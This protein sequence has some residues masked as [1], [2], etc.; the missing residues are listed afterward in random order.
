MSMRTPKRPPKSVGVVCR[1][2]GCLL[3]PWVQRSQLCWCILL[4]VLLLSGGWWQE[5]GQAVWRAWQQYP[6]H[7]VALSSAGC[8]GRWLCWLCVHLPMTPFV[9]HQQNAP[10]RNAAQHSAQGLIVLFMQECREQITYLRCIQLLVPRKENRANMQISGAQIRSS[11]SSRA[12]PTRHLHR[13][14]VR[15]SASLHARWCFDARCALGSYSSSSRCSL[16]VLLLLPN[17]GMAASRRRP[18]SCRSG[19]R[20][21]GAQQG[22]QHRTRASAVAR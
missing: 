16:P 13:T 12:Q 7:V 11:S 1:G 21:W 17:P 20:P 18:C 3:L 8:G 6:G 2:A 5:G 22:C 10:C 14:T 4:A 15:C 9:T 19:C